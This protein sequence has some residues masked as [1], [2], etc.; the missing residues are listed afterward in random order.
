MQLIIGSSEKNADLFYATRFIAPDP[1]VYLEVRGKKYILANDLEID[2]AKKEARV[3]AV[4]S[5]SRLAREYKRRTGRSPSLTGLV[6]GFLRKLG[7]KRL[8]VPEDFPVIH[9]DAL[10]RAGIK[11]ACKKGIFFEER[12]IKSKEE[13]RA[14]RQALRSTENAV[15]EA[16]KVLK[17]ST[18]KNGEL[19]YKGKLLT[20]KALRA[21]IHRSLLEQGCTGEHTI[22]SCGRASS[23]P[24]ERGHGPLR[25]HQ[26]IVIDIFP[27]N[28]R[29]L[30]HADFTRTFVRGKASSKLKKMF[31][32]VKAAQ[33]IACGMIRHGVPARKVHE[34]VCKKFEAAGFKTGFVNGRMQGFFHST[35]H[36][37]GLE[38]HE[39]PRISAGDDI[40][41]AGQIV[42]VEPG[43]YYRDAGGVRLED[44]VVVTKKGSMNLTKFPKKLEI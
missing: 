34:A 19:F 16:A 30:Y 9:A 20:S 2:R 28:D 11:L 27:R 41:R 14:I 6:T 25:A 36:G 17:R 29:T 15:A 32:A 31:A 37:L 21:V 38:I 26:P 8:T 42:T 5:T 7:V 13:V 3:H 43:L 44:M 1:F 33:A 24:H 35:G 39:P 18:I 22:V 4:I 40:L 10:R 12:L 23:N